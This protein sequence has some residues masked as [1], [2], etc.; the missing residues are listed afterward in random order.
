MTRNPPRY[1]KS[2]KSFNAE[3][4]R[5][6]NSGR[7]AGLRR[8]KPESWIEK[9]GNMF[10]RR[11]VLRSLGEGGSWAR[12]V[13]EGGFVRHSWSK[14]VS[15]GGTQPQGLRP[16]TASPGHLLHLVMPRE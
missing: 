14:G 3:L 2:D 11:L 7:T 5:A 15:E 8:V 16:G 12:V 10:V 9:P 4:R 13:S 6:A 1:Y